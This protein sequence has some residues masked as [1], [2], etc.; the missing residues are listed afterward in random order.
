VADDKRYRVHPLIRQRARELRQ[1][2]TPAEARLWQYLRR[3]QLNG[4]YFR[5]QHPIDH[6]IVDF[7]CAQARLV[8]EVDGDVHALQEEYDLAR[9]EYLEACSYRVIRFTNPEVF[10]TLESV[11]EQILKACEER[12]DRANDLE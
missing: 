7:Y 9:T 5:R 10:H 12:G 2:Q 3:R 4:Y 11:L 6:F 8:V 1:P